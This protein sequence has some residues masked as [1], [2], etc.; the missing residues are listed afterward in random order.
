VEGDGARKVP[1]VAA[2]RAQAGAQCL[3][4]RVERPEQV[5]AAGRSPSVVLR[6]IRPVEGVEAV[7][8][9]P[10]RRDNPH[11]AEK[12]GARVL[13]R[14]R[15]PH[16]PCDIGWWWWWWIFNVLVLVG[17]ESGH[18]SGR[19]QRVFGWRAGRTSVCT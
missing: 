15:P 19:V 17:A 4:Q 13:R 10:R 1:V 6:V 11:G 9:V 14:L 2:Q 18:G 5:A 16:V 3:G 8:S 12:V 7:Q